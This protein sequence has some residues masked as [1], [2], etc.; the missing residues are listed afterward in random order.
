[1]LCK[2]I[3]SKLALNPCSVFVQFVDKKESFAWRHVFYPKHLKIGG[4]SGRT[5]GSEKPL[6]EKES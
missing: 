6:D 3:E 5:K 2:R 1:M 4:N